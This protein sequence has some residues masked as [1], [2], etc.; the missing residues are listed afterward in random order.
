MSYVEGYYQDIFEASGT[1]N[2]EFY[3]D[4]IDALAVHNNTGTS[5]GKPTSCRIRV[6][7][8]RTWFFD[9]TPLDNSEFNMTQYLYR[10]LNATQKANYYNGSPP[11]LLEYAYKGNDN[12]TGPAESVNG[13]D[14][15]SILLHE[16]GHGLGM[17]GNVAFWEA[18]WDEEYDVDSDLVWGSTMAVPSY[19]SDDIYH[20]AGRS[21]MYPYSSVGQRVLPSATD[22]FAIETCAD[23]GD[24]TID[25]FRQDFYS[26]NTNGDF[27][28]RNNWSGHQVPGSADDVWIRHG[29]DAHLTADIRV[30]NLVVAEDV[31]LYTG[32]Y[33]LYADQ[34]C[35]LGNSSEYARVYI[36]NGGEFQ[37][38]KTLTVT[39]GAYVQMVTGSLL[40]V[41]SLTINNGGTL[42]GAG[43]V[44]IE[45]G[46]L[47][48]GAITVTGGDLIIDSDVAINLD[49]NGS[50]DG[51]G[52]VYVAGGDFSC[53]KA[54]TDSFSGYFR[55]DAGNEATFTEG[56]RI[57]S[58]GS[59]YLD[60][61]TSSA[62]RAAIN[63]GLFRIAGSLNVNQ[64]GRFSCVSQ[65]EADA[66]VLF[67][68]SDDTLYLH[69][70]STIQAGATFSG[71]GRLYVT[72]LS[73]TTL[74]DGASVGVRVHTNGLV[75][76]E[77][78]AVGDA[79]IGGDFS[80]NGTATLFVEADGDDSCDLLDIDGNATLDGTLY[81][82]FIDSYVPDD[83]DTF[84]VLTYNSRSGTFDY[85]ECSDPSVMLGVTYGATALTLT[86][87][88][89]DASMAAVPEP[90]TLALVLGGLVGLCL[91]RRR[92][93]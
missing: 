33:R 88:V 36:E 83:G 66:N 40:D 52:S 18:W 17:T 44:D 87:Y 65:F 8:N 16:M 47:N 73:E 7:T 54:L 4:N 48:R 72:S 56:W 39:D 86:A 91:I 41:D 37:V 34:N 30:N 12:G 2:V 46:L 43:T 22:I 31:T 93:K 11:D 76:V 53:N 14:L 71:S 25:L 89:G 20:V 55:V 82:D 81:L 5:G 77:E 42:Y 69:E 28:N 29:R 27:N 61:G 23:W 70:D 10:N 6:D 75:T 84:T 26:T 64:Q 45:D 38:D 19:S 57:N 49:G 13:F 78:G 3:Y 79:S 24:T 74:E 63:G 21:L 60:G 51:D 59:V 50:Y 9:E 80:M 15:W 90:G 58:T 68:D 32:V 35:T 67:A 92:C 85:I 1:L 62:T